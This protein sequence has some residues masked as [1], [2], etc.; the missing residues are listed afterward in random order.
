MYL[1]SDLL[2]LTAAESSVC[3]LK[4]RLPREENA[5]KKITYANSNSKN[6]TLYNCTVISNKSLSFCR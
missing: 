2:V 1:W 3:I 4:P 5:A 6:P